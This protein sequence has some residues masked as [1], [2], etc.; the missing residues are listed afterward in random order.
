MNI[1]LVSP[2]VPSK[3]AS[4]AGAVS[5]YSILRELS[6]SAR[7]TLVC[8]A[9]EEEDDPAGL[10]GFC[11]SVHT[12][13]FASVRSAGGRARA[14]LALSRLSSWL[15]SR[16]NGRPFFVQK[17]WN[18]ELASLLESVSGRQKFDVA[19]I[20]F[21]MMAQYRPHV[22]AR[23]AIL[24]LHEVGILPALR[25]AREYPGGLRGAI[26]RDDLRRWI[27]YEIE[28]ARSFDRVLCVTEKDRRVLIEHGAGENV[29]TNPHGI[30]AEEY[31]PEP[32]KVESGAMVFVGSFAHHVN[33][34]AVLWFAKEILPEI[35][36]RHPEARLYVVGSY[37]PP[38]VEALG[39]SENVVVTGFV[40]RVQD[41]LARA[42]VVLAPLLVG[43]G[44]KIKVLQALS[45]AKAI[46]TTPVGIDGIDGRDGVHFALAENASAFAHKT[47]E[48][49]S[50]S[51]LRDRMG[52][53]GRELVLE[54]YDWKVIAK[55]FFRAYEDA[56]S[57]AAR[58]AEAET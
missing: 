40:D 14:G 18:R 41:Y 31:A 7:V 54:R 24:D 19:Q 42:E 55:G 30:D 11:E 5:L 47:V 12:I 27:R 37:P 3:Q 15:A 36:E 46:V 1:L 51:G 44:I 10:S 20:E 23:C 4:H 38:Q 2:Y 45:M 35:L 49:L 25:F 58:N 56:S 22:S 16:R 13:P 8:L 52:A 39:R 53:K 17:Y 26:H 48:I 34:D 32:G 9:R 50:D 33:V 43:G 21:N 57:A 29:I 28:A 6:A